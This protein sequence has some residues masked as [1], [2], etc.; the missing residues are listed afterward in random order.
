MS[1]LHRRAAFTLI[2]LLVV[3]SIVALLVGLLLPALAASR[4][5]AR[6]LACSSNVRQLTIGQFAYAQDFGRFTIEYNASSTQRQFWKPTLAH[7]LGMAV[8]YDATTG[9]PRDIQDKDGSM[10][11]NCP[12]F[13]GDAADRLLLSYALNTNLHRFYS[14]TVAGGLASA[15]DARGRNPLTANRELVTITDGM[16]FRA[17]GNGISPHQVNPL[18]ANAV[19]AAMTRHS[20]TYGTAPS[21][22]G[23]GPV[24][25][26]GGGLT[27]S[28]TDGR[29]AYIG[30]DGP[31]TPPGASTPGTAPLRTG[32]DNTIGV[33][34][35][36]WDVRR[37]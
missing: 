23:R 5:V 32:P 27:V 33:D 34:N 13:E 15:S 6:Q 1:D 2:E 30:V 29:T 31:G 24:V 26:A 25:V 37:P 3:I 17:A 18:T 21:D 19:L 14:P 7:Y 9:L 12:A 10:P 28:T 36:H 16:I 20:G 8:I 11:F 22:V 4:R 35:R